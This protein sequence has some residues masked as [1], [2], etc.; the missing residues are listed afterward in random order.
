MSVLV[1]EPMQARCFVSSPAVVSRKH[2]VTV[3]L[4]IRVTI[5]SESQTS[6]KCFDNTS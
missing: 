3:L 1:D 4:D 2:E 5:Y 6:Y